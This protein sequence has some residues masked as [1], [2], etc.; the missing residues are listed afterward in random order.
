MNTVMIVQARMASTRLPGKVLREVLGKPLL[1]YQLERLRRAGTVN[2]TVIATTTR[3]V[4]DAIADFCE[5]N[6][7]ACFRGSEDDVLDRYYNA[8]LENDADIVVRVTSDCPLIDPAVIDRVVK[9]YLTN[10]DR[11]DYVSNTLERT[12]PRG[13]DT[14]VVSMLALAEAHHEAESKP[15]R[16]HVTPFFYR[17]PER[18]RLMSVRNDEDLSAH[19]WTVDTPEDFELIR[20]IITALYAEKPEF[21]MRD[22]LD[23]IKRNPDWQKLN[24][25]IMQKAY[26]Q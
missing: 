26:G 7:V 20:R 1:G 18:Y 8:A 22:C 23:L 10:S 21:T 3:G 14:E 25:D 17:Q 12:Y 15:D 24:Q 13:M 9:T 11:T 16:E 4:D 2:R 6:E 19:R 5:S